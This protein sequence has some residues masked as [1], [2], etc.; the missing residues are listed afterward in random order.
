MNSPA[1]RTT[2]W[3]RRRES[4]AGWNR[5]AD[6]GP[7]CFRADGVES[8]ASTCRAMAVTYTAPPRPTSAAES[9]M[10]ICTCGRSARLRECRA[11]GEDS[12]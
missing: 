7:E 11:R 2:G 10:T 12:P 3:P 6:H 8:G 9:K 4:S 5:R 1:R